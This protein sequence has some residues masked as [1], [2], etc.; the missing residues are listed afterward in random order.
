[1]YGG[2]GYSERHWD[3]ARSE[4]VQGEWSRVEREERH[5]LSF[6]SNVLVPL[7]SGLAVGIPA[8][9]MSMV[10]AWRLHGVVMLWVGLTFGSLIWFLVSFYVMDFA[11]GTFR[12]F[13]EYSGGRSDSEMEQQERVVE[14]L[15]LEVVS[16]D[17]QRLQFFDGIGITRD[18]FAL[19]A[20]SVLNGRS[21]SE[22]SWTGA[23]GT[24]KG[25][26]YSKMLDY[27]MRAGLVKWVKDGVPW[28]GR[29]LTPEGE[30][31]LARF[32]AGR[33]NVLEG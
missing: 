9:I 6:E 1:M 16:A 17:G 20:R 12:R 15:R 29:E 32:V 7:T 4:A 31:T 33:S 22:S 21:L 13:D 8:G 5:P 11:L 25:P 27:L 26:E 3:G 2:R 23:A 14:T 24:F 19:W 10:A 18:S 28:Q 30:S